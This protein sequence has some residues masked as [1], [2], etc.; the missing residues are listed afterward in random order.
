MAIRL[1]VFGLF[2]FLCSHIAWGQY[3]EAS[4]APVLA[5]MPYSEQ[6]GRGFEASYRYAWSGRQS[7]GA[8]F[9]FQQV[10]VI[11][12]GRVPSGKFR[13][14]FP[15]RASVLDVYFS[16]HFFPKKRTN[17]LASAGFSVAY[18]SN[19]EGHIEI[20]IDD[21]IK[22]DFRSRR[23]AATYLFSSGAI[24]RSLS[25]RVSLYGRLSVRL[26]AG[27]QPAPLIFTY[28]AEGSVYSVSWAQ[29]YAHN[30]MVAFALG[31]SYRL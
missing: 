28:Y 23:A 20:G 10:R 2:L 16:Q 11:N 13:L 18:L 27:P 15:E 8:T 25:D 4:V 31:L 1:H 7:V 12:E 5:S 24:T 21:E 3:Q 30:S 9:S 19:M 26:P 22:E 14:T 17:F 29:A 6:I